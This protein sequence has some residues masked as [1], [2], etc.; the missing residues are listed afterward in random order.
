MCVCLCDEPRHLQHETRAFLIFR[1]QQVQSLCACKC[2]FVCVC[3]WLTCG[4]ESQPPPLS[5]WQSSAGLVALLTGLF[6]QHTVSLSLAAVASF[7]GLPWPLSCPLRWHRGRC[8]LAMGSNRWL[9]MTFN[10]K[11]ESGPRI[12]AVITARMYHVIQT[13]CL[14][15]RWKVSSGFSFKASRVFMFNIFFCDKCWDK[16]QSG[17]NDRC[18]LCFF[19]VKEGVKRCIF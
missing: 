15:C 16:Y 8:L 9:K 17:E 10:N 4:L 14:V 18:F 19:F 2:V 7:T 1:V 3:A 5:H 12:M 11:F 13:Y 6:L